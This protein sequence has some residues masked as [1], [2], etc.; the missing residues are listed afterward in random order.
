MSRR[1]A[2]ATLLALAW[3]AAGPGWAAAHGTLIRGSLTL[4][5]DP[6]RPGQ[7]MVLTIDLATTNDSP[8]EGAKLV[9]DLTP[10]APAGSTAAAP[11]RVIPIQEY[12]EPYGTYRAQ[13]TAPPA[14]S[15]VLSIHDR[16]QPGEDARVELPLRIG[17]TVAN[18]SLGFTFPGS[19]ASH[20]LASWLVWL[21]GVPLAAGIVVTILVRRS[22]RGASSPDGGDD[23]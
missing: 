17:G 9:A 18:G 22:A 23:A 12:K 4:A 6:P 20:G 5:P 10:E 13:L 1:L 11:P 15:Y 21:I 16:T 8:V 3:V 19:G 2:V 7:P 14:G